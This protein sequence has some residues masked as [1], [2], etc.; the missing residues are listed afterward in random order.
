MES[1]LMLHCGG[2]AV[3]REDLQLIR[4]PEET[5]TY[6]PVSHFDLATKIV[7]ISQD[8]LKGYTMTSESYG[9][10]RDGARM[11]AVI[12][13]KNG[14]P[15]MGL[16]LGFR[17]SYDKSMILGIACGASVFVCDNLSLSAQTG[18][19]IMRK[20][21]GN[22]WAELED[23]LISVCY[24]AGKGYEILTAS[25]NA[26]KSIAWG[27][28]QAY[29]TMGE[30]FGT[31]VVSPR[32]VVALRDEWLKP[33]HEAFQPRNAW[34]FYNCCTEILKSTP[35]HLVMEKH[36]ELTKY[37]DDNVIDITPTT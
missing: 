31:E 26:M 14:N 30:L 23:R 2:Q 25:S 28:K 8:L 6:K 24:K 36:L 16:A 34:S 12:N 9:I 4:V 22:V 7:T 1:R 5:P 10:A 19:T 11:F 33:R 15:E 13:F 3:S 32:Q 37:F 17:N 27:N 29:Q 21:T 35:P 18:I 20:H